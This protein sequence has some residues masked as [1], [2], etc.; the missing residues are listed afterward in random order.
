MPAFSQPESL[1][2]STL[3]PAEEATEAENPTLHPQDQAAAAG[4]VARDLPIPRLATPRAGRTGISGTDDPDD[5]D[6]EGVDPKVV[7][8]LAVAL[9]TAL[10]TIAAVAVKR[11]RPRRKLRRP[12]VAQLRAVGRAGADIAMRHLE[13]TRLSP[14]LVDAI[15]IAG[16]VGDYLEDG[17]VTLPDGPG[18]P[19][20]PHDLHQED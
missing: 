15:K 3:A 17:P 11:T 12:T 20:I 5:S 7:A 14:D 2:R 13:I 4:D 19:G 9:L 10:V 8:G 16:T 1:D 18:D 6:G